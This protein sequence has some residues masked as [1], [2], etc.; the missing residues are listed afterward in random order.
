[1]QKPPEPTLEDAQAGFEQALAEL[2][3]IV[4][5]MEDGQ[6]PLEESLSAYQRGTELVKYCEGR[7][8]EAQARIAVLEG[9]SLRDLK[10]GDA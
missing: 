3:A 5:R 9:D 8:A 4:Q 7:L 1:M 6:L 2:E 10:V